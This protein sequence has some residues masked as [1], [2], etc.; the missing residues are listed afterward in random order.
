[1]ATTAGSSE[2]SFAEDRVCWDFVPP[3]FG[4]ADGR[5][6]GGVLGLGRMDQDFTR[7]YLLTSFLNLRTANLR[8]P[9]FLCPEW[10]NRA[11]LACKVVS[12]GSPAENAS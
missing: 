8:G 10:G 11:N 3:P 4:A 5:L 12:V 6:S 1:M 2:E 7:A 9:S